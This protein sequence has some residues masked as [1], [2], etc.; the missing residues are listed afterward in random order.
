MTI[1]ELLATQSTAVLVPLQNVAR[2]H[3]THNAEWY[4][5]VTG[6]MWL[7]ESD[8]DAVKKLAEQI[9]LRMNSPATVTTPLKLN[10]GVEGVITEITRLIAETSITKE[11]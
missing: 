1:A 9:Q 3:Q 2:E 8:E 10:A 11:T 7:R 5:Q 4:S 6:S